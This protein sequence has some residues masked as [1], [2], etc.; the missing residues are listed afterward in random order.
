MKKSEIFLKQLQKKDGVV[1]FNEPLSKHTSFGIGGN[2]KYFVIVKNERTLVEIFRKFQRVFVIGA[3]TNILFKNKNFG[4]MFVKLSGS[5]LK[6]RTSKNKITVGSGVNLFLLNKILKEKNL[7]GIEF[8]FGIPGTVGGAI[9]MN[10]GAFGNEIGNYVEKVKIFDGKRVFWTKKFD[11]SYRNSS[12]KK[13]KQIILSVTF[14]LS[15]LKSEEIAEKQNEFITKR[16]LSQP[17]GQRSAGS[18]FKRI[19]KNGE[20]LYPAKMIDKLGLKGVKKGKAR[21][22]EK[23]AGFIV[24]ENGAKFEDVVYLI[25]KI[26]KEVRRKYNEILK[27]EIIIFKGRRN[28]YFGRLSHTH[29][30]FKR[31]T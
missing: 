18:V 2:A 7:G 23:H 3:G 27:E 6:T 30:L 28:E 19:Y 15:P 17:Y 16:K 9:F 24:C 26:K 21:I 10:A 20:M 25:K 12:F 13:N 14:K 29:N 22:S 5:F 1:L 11:F 4:E 31:K 8:T